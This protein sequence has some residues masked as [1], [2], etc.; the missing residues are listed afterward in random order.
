MIFSVIDVETTGLFKKDRIVE[1]GIVQI[2]DTGETLA[3]FET[4]V[5]PMRDIGNSDIHGIEA[6]H[7]AEAPVFNEIAHTVLDFMRKSDI[8]V[9]HNFAFDW[10]MLGYEFDRLKYRLPDPVNGLCTMNVFQLIDPGC[11]RRLATLCSL[12]DIPLGA[13]HG[14]INDSRA[15]AELLK[16]CLGYIDF[17]NLV[18]TEW[19]ASSFVH[20]DKRL[21]RGDITDQGSAP[22]F[23][24]AERLIRDLPSHQGEGPLDS[25]FDLLDRVF[26]DSILEESEAQQLID[27]ANSLG[28][29]AEQTRKAHETY[30]RELVAVAVRDGYISELERQHLNAVSRALGLNIKTDLKQ[31]ASLSLYPRDLKGKTICFTGEM[32]G[33]IDGQPVDRKRACKIAEDLGLEVK[34]GVSKKL[35]LLVVKDP[36]TMSGKARKAREYKIPIVAEQ[37]FW[38]WSGLQAK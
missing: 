30:F 34:S 28:M 12:Y 19:N 5:N 10:K 20:S 13:Q 27:L 3:E 14:A 22:R 18:P 29:S 17:S 31:L 7:V 38:I 6:R 2:D 21:K 37:V 24:V 25:Y 26:A 11:P 16:M 36:Y 35:D 4:L 15:T 33:R 8:I 32:R 23:S 9:G 1:V